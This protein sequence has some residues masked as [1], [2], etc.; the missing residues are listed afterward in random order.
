MNKKLLGVLG[1]AA[2]LLAGN[3]A[4]QKDE[5]V[6]AAGHPEKLYLT[7]ASNWFEKDGSGKVPRFA[8]YFFGNG[9]TWASMTDE[10]GDQMFEVTV[11]TNKVYPNVIFCRMNPSNNTNNWNNKYNQTGDLVIPTDGKNHY[12]VKNGTWDSGGGTWS[13]YTPGVETAK[14]EL[15]N[16]ILE[17][18][19]NDGYYVRETQIYLDQQA[20]ADDLLSSPE[21]ESKKYVELFHAESNHLNRTTY[22]E[23]DQLWMTNDDKTINSGY[24]TEGE[25]MT[26][27]TYENGVKKVDYRVDKSHA[28]WENKL[29]NGMEGFYTTLKDIV[30][31]EEQNWE[32]EVENVYSSKNE[33][34]IKKFKAFTAPCY[35]GFTDAPNYITFDRVEIEEKSNKLELRLYASSVESDKLSSENNLFSKATISACSVQVA[36][37][38]NE[39][40]NAPKI[41]RTDIGY[42]TKINLT[43]NSN[44]FKLIINGTWYGNDG[45]YSSAK[46]GESWEFWGDNPSNCKLTVAAG[47]YIFI[48][49]PVSGTYPKVTI[50][51]A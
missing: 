23:G 6:D 9:E 4:W 39:W 48:V 34:L 7:P 33:E 10:D 47:T 40:G 36:G 24:G 41:N 8:A 30:A 17:S 15:I 31:V 25:L 16:G 43:T 21:T 14:H 3:F 5:V 35:T 27:F 32:E 45:T 44:E 1:V 12:T 26:H 20:V 50:T 19:L 37:S 11:P 22:F 38:F 46:L 51:A 49:D 18:Y 28:D 42:S 2:L 29:E 13:T